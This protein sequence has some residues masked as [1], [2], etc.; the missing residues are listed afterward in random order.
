MAVGREVLAED[1]AGGFAVRMMDENLAQPM[2]RCGDDGIEQG[3]VGADRVCH[4]HEFDLRFECL[5]LEAAQELPAGE[6]A[7]AVGYQEAV[8]LVLGASA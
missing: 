2:W 1:R 7:I 3:T 4:C 6:P 5:G 8:E